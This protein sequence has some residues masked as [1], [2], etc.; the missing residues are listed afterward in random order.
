MRLTGALLVVVLSILAR[1][2]SAQ[3]LSRPAEPDRHWFFVD[4]NFVGST[5]SLAEGVEYLGKSVVASELA[6]FKAAYP[7]PSDARV[8]P[9]LDV[10]GGYMVNP[11]VGIGVG[12]SQS[13]YENT[14]ALTAT[15][16]HPFFLQIPATG[17]GET[18]LLQRTES[19]THFFV[20]VTALSTRRTEW[21]FSFGPTIFS[22]AA[23]MVTDVT[24]SQNAP[25]NNP[26]NIVTVTGYTTE[27]ARGTSVGAHVSSD[28]AFNVA[29]SVAIT[30]GVRG[31]VGEVK[32]DPE[33]LS[34]IK[35]DVRVGDWRVF[36]GVR[37]RVGKSQ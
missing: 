25:Q 26:Q 29:R 34:G 32:I 22:L 24:Y 1:P 31:S 10:S 8:F 12:F 36:V 35:Q 11:R 7:K 23:D 14:A 15:V 27:E 30:G 33:P 3:L 5:N 2:A 28:F 16:P 6:T 21:R 18:D 13:S 19:A 20:T 9:L 4:V 17:T 37:W